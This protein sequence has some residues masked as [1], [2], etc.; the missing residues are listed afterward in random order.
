M[1]FVAVWQAIFH[2]EGRPRS[3]LLRRF[4]RN[5]WTCF[6][7]LPA[8]LN[9]PFRA[10][11]TRRFRATSTVL[12]ICNRNA[13]RCPL[14]GGYFVISRRAAMR[15]GLRRRTVRE[16]VLPAGCETRRSTENFTILWPHFGRDSAHNRVVNHTGRLQTSRLLQHRFL[17]EH[18][19]SEISMR[20]RRA[21]Q[22]G[23]QLP[24]V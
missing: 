1:I 12:F 18:R 2:P 14:S 16:M 23:R 21:E 24:R 19:A 4:A 22:P 11:P 3:I 8:A 9:L 13:T 10:R 6:G 15:R 17:P 5:D 7:P 20:T